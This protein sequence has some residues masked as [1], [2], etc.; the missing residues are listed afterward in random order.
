MGD[1][2]VA[3][4]LAAERPTV[5]IQCHGGSAAI[6]S[7]VAAFE[8]AG[9]RRRHG[10]D[11]GPGPTE[12]PIAAD[13]L[14]DL[15]HAPTLRTAE[16]LLDQVHGALRREVD[17]L[18]RDLER[19]AVPRARLEAL[20]QR[21]AIGLRL[22]TGWKVVIAGR[23]NV[24]KSRL[25]NALAGFA[26]AIV[27]PTAGVTRDVVTFRTA[28]GGWPI[29]LADTAGV[30]STDDPIESLGIARS[31]REQTGADLVLLVLDRSEPL[32]AED[33]ELID[34]MPGALLVVNKSDLPA[35]WDHRESLP[36]SSSIVILSAERGEGIVGLVGA[37]AG[38]LV[39]DSPAPGDPVPFRTAHLE[40][41]RHTRAGL[42]AGDRAGA[43]EWLAGM[44]SGHPR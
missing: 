5:E 33:R 39:P 34:S 41:L 32:R 24:G 11:L 29:E 40:A 22:L 3:V 8:A 18:L 42:V 7:V 31:R 9:A 43:V 10:G 37:I 44:N 6:E 38:H 26:R 4:R 13:A 30:R 17:R 12:D 28:F 27:D 21:S 23:P 35:A 19:G 1:E 2:V 20:I 15:P 14:N 25:F 16:V 36:E